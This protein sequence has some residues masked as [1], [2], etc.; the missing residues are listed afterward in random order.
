MLNDEPE[1]KEYKDVYTSFHWVRHS[2]TSFALLSTFIIG[3]V[4]EFEGSGF[5]SLEF[6]G[7]GVYSDGFGFSTF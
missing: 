5:S 4:F 7:S 2:Q 1:T 6:V 3:V